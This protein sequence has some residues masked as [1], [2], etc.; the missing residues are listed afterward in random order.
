MLHSPVRCLFCRT[1]AGAFTR[2]EHTIPES[3][4][5]TDQVLP[6]GR[7]CDSCNQ[8]FGTRVEQPA[9]ATPPFAIGRA[10][11]AVPTKK[12]RMP[13]YGRHGEPEIQGS[14]Y[15]EALLL[16]HADY[17]VGSPED[18][19][20][21]LAIPMQDADYRHILRLLLKMGLELVELEVD[22]TDAFGTEFDPARKLARYAPRGTHWQLGYASLP[23]AVLQESSESDGEEVHH[24]LY[25]YQVG[26]LPDGQTYLIFVLRMQLFACML[27]TP[28]LQAFANSYRRRNAPEFSV[29]DVTF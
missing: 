29:L 15:Y 1:E 2:D 22:D 13:G 6:P 10:L 5:N 18:G 17:V 14:G 8:Y 27:T 7:V 20:V 4:G 11:S 3:L 12:R 16:G 26:T 19:R 21:D 28:S 9:L 24:Q 23:R 25:Q